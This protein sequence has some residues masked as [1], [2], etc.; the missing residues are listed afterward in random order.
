MDALNRDLGAG[1]DLD[2]ERDLDAGQ[3]I[4]G[5]MDMGAVH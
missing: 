2:A 3:A 5:A 4:P 1:Q